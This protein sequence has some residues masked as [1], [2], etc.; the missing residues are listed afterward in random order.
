MRRGAPPPTVSVATSA[1]T[2]IPTAPSDAPTKAFFPE[3]IGAFCVQGEATSYGKDAKNPIT[4]ICDLFDGECQLYLELSVERA[5]EVRYL[6]PTGALI[7]IR[8]SKFDTSEHAFAM[9]ST[10][11]VGDFDPA[12]DAPRPLDVGDPKLGQRASGL[13]VG[14]VLFVKGAWLFEAEYK[15]NKLP[16]DAVKAAADETLSDL[17]KKVVAALPAGEPPAL[18][19]SVPEADRVPLG[20]RFDA[21][22]GLKMKGVG[23][24]MLGYHKTTDGRRYR[25]FVSKSPDA[26]K[27]QNVF[28]LL[29]AKA[30]DPVG[31]NDA[32]ARVEL[33][34]GALSLEWVFAVSGEWVIGVGDESRVL[35]AGVTGAAH[36]DLCL[37]TD[38]KK[39]F[40][41]DWTKKLGG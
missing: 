9:F 35:R 23:P 22:D 4:G 13:G 37:P 10:R 41:A 19:S 14:N 2:C 33:K 7:S 5:V 27:A 31:P 8:L 18:L 21:I 28:K 38:K 24:A 32:V 17:V 3:R 34:E 12:V 15:D 29:A 39:Q 36:D 6:A 20:V 16:V 1:G 11:V 25:T 26:A 30:L 40:V